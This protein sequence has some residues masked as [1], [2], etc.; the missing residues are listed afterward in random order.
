[1]T[2]IFGSLRQPYALDQLPESSL[3]F[4]VTFWV[5]KA[6]MTI[7]ALYVSMTTVFVELE[8]AELI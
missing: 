7:V 1:M 2:S 8:G 5:V 6:T 3:A 4:L